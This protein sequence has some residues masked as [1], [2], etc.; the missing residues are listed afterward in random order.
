MRYRLWILLLP[1]LL[2]LAAGWGLGYYY[3]TND[4]LTIVALLRGTTAAAPVSDLHLYFHGYAALWSWLYAAAPA[5]P[6]YGLTLYGLL[7][8]A[9]VLGAAV[10]WRVLRAR[11][12]VGAALALLVLFWMVGWLEHGFWFNY[13]R[14]PLLLAGAG[15][16]FAAQR[17]PARWAL[18][19]GVLAFGLSWLIRPSAAVLG[20]VVALPGAWYLAGRRVGPI[21]AG[22]AA[23]A[24]LGALWLHLTWSPQAA[25]FRRLDVLKSN[26]NDFQL[27]APPRGPLRPADSLAL[28]AAQ[29]WQLGDSTLV[30]EAS[31]DRVAPFRLGYFLRHTAPAKLVALARQLPRDYFPL[32]LLLAA[33]GT[34]VLRAGGGHRGFW[35]VQAG[36]AGLLLGLGTLL[37]LPPRLALPLLDFWAL[38]NLIYLWQLRPL[39]RHSL[40]VLLLVLLATAIPYGY[41][42]RHR[43]QV[44]PQEAR[45]NYEQRERLTQLARGTQIVVSDALEETYKSAS[46]FTEGVVMQLI[47]Y[48][49]P[50]PVWLSVRGWQT[51][52]P[53]Q[54]ALRKQL[55]GTRDFT[56]ALRNLGQR[57]DV[58]WLL[59]PKAAALLNGQLARARQPNEPVAWLERRKWPKRFPYG[60]SS[61]TNGVHAYR[62]RTKFPQLSTKAKIL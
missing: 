11:T 30:N 36:Y 12:G 38:S 43:S 13:V 20:F 42:T 34:L 23:W 53:S 60:F 3:E 55:T 6:W 17:A 14:V 29:A 41:K 4:D 32:L 54:V 21:V 19:V 16:L 40:A 2:L 52:H 1:L 33:T 24:V 26:L 39:P 61:P 47:P 57:T 35:L 31:L 37:K 15:V 5:W 48:R 9:T 58:A 56:G 59:T 27:A 28:A 51:L 25:T 7:Y 49:L 8:A 10:L 46:P 50:G 45:A 62:M 22:A 18:L 44:L